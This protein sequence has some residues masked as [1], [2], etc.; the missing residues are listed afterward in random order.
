MTRRV[1]LLAEIDTTLS[2][3]GTYTG[4]W[5]DTS[6]VLTIKA[7]FSVG[8]GSYSMTLDQSNDQSVILIQDSPPTLAG[9][10]SLVARY[11]RISITGGSANA[12]FRGVIRKVA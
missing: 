5:I 12:T 4:E 9:Y 3:S 2:A 10:S 7:F 8:G 11:F 6:E 1:D